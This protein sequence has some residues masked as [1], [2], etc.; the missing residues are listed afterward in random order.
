MFDPLF[1]PLW[2]APIAGDT[3]AARETRWRRAAT[4]RVGPNFAKEP[5]QP[6]RFEHGPDLVL[7]YSGLLRVRLREFTCDGRL[8]T[9]PLDTPQFFGVRRQ[10]WRAAVASTRAVDRSLTRQ[11]NQRCP[12]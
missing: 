8:A 7:A 12:I 3:G 1:D 5:E 2:K 10:I 11:M 9:L 6:N 4:G